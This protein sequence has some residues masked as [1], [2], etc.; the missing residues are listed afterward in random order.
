M[1]KKK[2]V[3]TIKNFLLTIKI[4]EYTILMNSLT[5]RA[6]HLTL[7]SVPFEEDFKKD[8]VVQIRSGTQRHLHSAPQ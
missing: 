1:I 6:L 4:A 7:N 5:S 3:S 2:H 8:N